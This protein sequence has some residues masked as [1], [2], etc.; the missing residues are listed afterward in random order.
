V[1]LGVT[2]RELKG[3]GGYFSSRTVVYGGPLIRPEEHNVELVLDLMLMQLIRE[4]KNRSVFIQFRNFKDMK[5]RV[6]TFEKYRFIY[7]DRLNYLVDTS[8]PSIVKERIGSEKMRQVRKGIKKGAKIVPP[9]SE[10]E[11]RELY[12]I[13]E[14]LYRYK[15]KKPLPEW[16][17]F[18]QFYSM[19]KEG[20]LGIIQLV[21]YDG[22]VIGGIVCP[23]SE[24]KTIYEWYV[25][26]LDQEYKD[27]YPSVM[28]TWSAINHALKNGISTFDFMGVGIP[29]RSYGVRK[30][31][32]R[33]GGEMVNYGRFARVNNRLVYFISE[34]G[35]NLL[36][37][38]KRI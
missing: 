30:F 1:L 36:A 28:A 23:I 35:Y 29:G 4:T 5:G 22:K 13:L 9:K 20:K 38:M 32:S 8:S 19:A 25:C 10:E 21:K 37:L 31:K 27:L 26:G 12:L 2:I 11:V 17:F 33:F 18:Q 24:D 15:V 34:M 16:S 7:R 6:D 3:I 14:E